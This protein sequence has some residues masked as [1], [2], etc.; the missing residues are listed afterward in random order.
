MERL[1]PQV[2]RRPMIRL[3]QSLS[4]WGTPEFEAVLKRE[5]AQLGGDRLPLQQGLSTSSYVVEGELDVLIHGASEDAG[6]IRVQAGIFY[7]GIVAGCSCAD[8]PTPVDENSEYCE[9]QVEI[10]KATAEAT[11]TLL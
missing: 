4:A 6:V 9:V 8:D 7:K 11:V 2:F 1:P 5:I 10:D 3:T